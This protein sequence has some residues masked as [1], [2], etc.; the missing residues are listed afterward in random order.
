MSTELIWFV[1]ESYAGPPPIPDHLEGPPAPMH[2]GRP[3][4]PPPGPCA[5]WSRPPRI[6][7][8][9]PSRHSMEPPVSHAAGGMLH[10]ALICFLVQ[11]ASIYMIF[12][13]ESGLLVWNCYYFAVM[14]EIFSLNQKVQFRKQT[15][16]H[17]KSQAS[18]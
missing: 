17:F 14:V 13:G 16:E 18:C 11:V 1:V 15:G 10:V 5:G 2:Y 12:F 3:S 4:D 8:Y 9:S 7:N 6:S